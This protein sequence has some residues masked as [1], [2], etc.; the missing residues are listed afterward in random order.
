M[1]EARR[2]LERLGRI[3]E[4]RAS[5]APPG[6]IV[7]ELRALVREGEAWIAAEGRGTADARRALASLDETLHRSA[8]ALEREGVVPEAGRL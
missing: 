2:V 4:L 1:E 5:G 7:P 3:D 6:S 8:E